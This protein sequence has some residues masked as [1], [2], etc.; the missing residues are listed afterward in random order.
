MYQTACDCCHGSFKDS[1]MPRSVEHL[2]SLLLL[3]QLLQ[4]GVAL[5]LFD[6][7]HLLFEELV[8]DAPS[9]G[10]LRLVHVVLAEHWFAAV[11]HS[12]WQRQWLKAQ[13]HR[14]ETPP[15]I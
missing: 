3:G 10:H 15:R 8:R 5:A 13:L 1:L 11:G 9:L 7:G 6:G 2:F 12:R 4:D 14:R